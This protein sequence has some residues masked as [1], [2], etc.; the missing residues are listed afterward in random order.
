MNTFYSHLVLP[1]LF[2]LSALGLCLILSLRAGF[3]LLS[4]DSELTAKLAPFGIRS[5]ITAWFGRDADVFRKN[6]WGLGALQI[7]VHWMNTNEGLS[8]ER[9]CMLV[10]LQQFCS[11]EDRVCA[12]VGVQ[13]MM[14]Q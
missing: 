4:P 9:L 8:C 14:S 1:S 6:Q 2:E 13:A 5:A 12:E 11:P 7:R 3:T 10:T